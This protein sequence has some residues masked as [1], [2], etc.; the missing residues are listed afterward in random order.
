MSHPL[1]SV[2][3]SELAGSVDAEVP[4]RALNTFELGGAAR[5]LVVPAGVEDIVATLTIC[6]NGGVA[7]YVLG[8]GSNIL[9]PDEG[10][11]GVVLRLPGGLTGIELR[12]GLVEVEA[13]VLDRDLAEFACLRGL[14][15]FEW[16]CDIPGS[17]GGAIF[18]NAGN[19]DGDARER[20]E[21][22]TIL[23]ADGRRG[24]LT[25]DECLLSYRHSRFQEEPAIILSAR[26]RPAGR[27]LPEAI[28]GRMEA[29][30]QLRRS[31]F[32]LEQ[33]C[34]GS[35]FKRPPGHF[36]GRLIE[37]AGCGGMRVGGAEVANRHKGFIVNTGGATA[38]QVKELIELVRRRVFD[39]SGIWLEPEVAEFKPLLASTR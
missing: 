39:H 6:R 31:K 20:L 9:V 32:P 7:L 29:I 38:A 28:A 5:L 33:R 13:G 21:S 8:A 2:L 25:A 3:S 15:G 34:A 22:V 12:D 18:M 27:D 14:A 16:I 10:V 26:F 17:V 24:T 11:D 19:N 23:W 35:V 30:R 36:A 37:E 1:F 4:L